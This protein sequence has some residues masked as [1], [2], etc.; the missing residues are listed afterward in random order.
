MS[1]DDT[2]VT[3]SADSIAIL[4]LHMNNELLNLENWQIANK[5]SLNDGKLSLF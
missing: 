5:L 1:A 3:F 4:E 2:T